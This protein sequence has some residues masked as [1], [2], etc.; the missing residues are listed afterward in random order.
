[1][2]GKT[3]KT[4]QNKTK[5]TKKPEKTKKKKITTK[6]SDLCDSVRERVFEK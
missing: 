6:Q 5:K 1:M 3:N 4:K 2:R